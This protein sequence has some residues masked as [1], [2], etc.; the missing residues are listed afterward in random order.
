M[1]WCIMS[2]QVACGTSVPSYLNRHSKTLTDCGM[3][4]FHANVSFCYFYEIKSPLYL[5]RTKPT[6]TKANRSAKSWHQVTEAKLLYDI[7]FSWT[8]QANEWCP[9][10]QFLF[11]RGRKK[12]QNDSYL[13]RIASNFTLQTINNFKPFQSMACGRILIATGIF[14]FVSVRTMG[15]DDKAN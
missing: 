15:F 14:T 13:W 4:Y 7:L 5:K 10:I 2:S 3:S 9:W 1:V 8:M 12:L 6:S 11:L